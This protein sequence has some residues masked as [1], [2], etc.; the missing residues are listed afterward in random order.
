MNCYDQETSKANTVQLRN[1][2]QYFIKYDTF[3]GNVCLYRYLR[4]IYV[5][6]YVYAKTSRNEEMIN[7]KNIYISQETLQDQV[8]KQ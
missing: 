8:G 3:Y 4:H 2:V 1:F 6:A 5:F 7:A